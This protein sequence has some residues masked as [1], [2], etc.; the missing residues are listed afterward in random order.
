M[1]ISWGALAGAIA[2]I[3]DLILVPVVSSLTKVDDT[4]RIDDMFSEMQ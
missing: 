3:T 4:K 2:M 1:S